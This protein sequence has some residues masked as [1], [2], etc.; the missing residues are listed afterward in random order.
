SSAAPSIRR[1]GRPRRHG[2]VRGRD[3]RR[4][5]GRRA[6]R[7]PVAFS[8]SAARQG[9]PAKTSSAGFGG[10]RRGKS[11][12]GWEGGAMKRLAVLVCAGSAVAAAMLLAGPA[13][14]AISPKLAVT[15]SNGAGAA[16]IVSGGSSSSAEDPFAKIQ[17]YVPTGFALNAPAGGA[18]VGTATGH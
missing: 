11:H 13:A 2:G 16:L 8:A 18:A 7:R 15:P 10:R 1:P 17:L 6:P 12:L 14:A 9:L 3:R 4:R 5:R